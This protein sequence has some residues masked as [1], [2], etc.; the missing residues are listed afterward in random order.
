M[1]VDVKQIVKKKEVELKK[2][3]LDNNIKPTL[4]VI[5]ANNFA[6]SESYIASK[7]KKANELG[8]RQI[9]F[10][11]DKDV[12]EEEIVNKINE[13]NKDSSVNGIL[14]Q[15]PLYTH[16]NEYN[17]INSVSPKKDVDGFTSYNLGNI[18]NGKENIIPCTPKGILLILENLNIDVIGKNVVI[19]GRSRIVGRP[20]A[21]LMISRGATVTICNSKTKNLS[22]YTK[23][24]DILIVAIGNPK[25]VTSNMVKKGSIVLDVGINRQDGKLVGDVDTENI[26]DIVKYVTPV[27]GGI[28]LA[29][30]ISLMD[31]LVNITLEY[32][33]K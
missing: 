2:L 15:L 6:S 23:E 32:I 16:L 12:T 20:I 22:K 10:K 14:V 31:N 5:H 25:F 28:G 29:T 7:R 17:I 26:K 27:P 24:A 18:V 33:K 13:L 21:E 19:M 8:I 1:I 4:A 3:I 11:Y 9:E 30:V